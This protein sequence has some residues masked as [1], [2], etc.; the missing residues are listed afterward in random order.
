MKGRSR[1][2]RVLGERYKWVEGGTKWKVGVVEGST[3]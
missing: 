1:L 3:K 2:R